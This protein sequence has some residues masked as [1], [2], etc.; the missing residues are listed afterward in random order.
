M[1][2]F[3]YSWGNNSIFLF[4]CGGISMSAIAEYLLYKGFSVFGYDKQ[5]S[6]EVRKLESKGMRFLHP[7]ELSD[8]SAV[9]IYTSAVENTEDFMRLKAL[10]FRLIKRSLA[11][12]EIQSRYKF[13]IAVSG[14]HGKTT[15]TAMLAHVL[16]C[17]HKH[18]TA[19]IGGHDSEFGNL[20]IGGNRVCVTEACEFRAN[21]LDLRKNVA[22]VLNVDNDHLDSYGSFGN[23]KKSFCEFA[24]NSIAVINADDE[25]SNGIVGKKTVTFG[26]KKTADYTAK[27]IIFTEETTFKVFYRGRYKAEITLNTSGI[28]N[29]YNA[30]AVIASAR[31]YKISWK[32]IREGLIDFT[33]VKRRSEVIGSIGGVVAVCDYAHHPTEV[34]ATLSGFTEDTLVVFQPH[35]YSRTKILMSEFVDALKNVKHLALYKTYSAREKYKKEGSAETLYRTLIPVAKHNVFYL[36]NIKQLKEIITSCKGIKKVAFIGAGNIYDIAL[37]LIDKK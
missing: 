30:L 18:P 35:T 12:S 8:L 27:D 17:A 4:G 2:K 5:R 20:L 23:L 9:V 26:I 19:F 13:N 36:K 3:T 22:I 33:G 15:S 32:N 31:V 16:K 29:V 25:K 7:K 10:G 1:S 21:F 24:K 34:K 11:I 37:K 28:H 14:S 6:R